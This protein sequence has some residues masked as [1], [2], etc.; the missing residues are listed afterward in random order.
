MRQRGHGHNEGG[1]WRISVAVVKE[2]VDAVL[3]V[4]WK[5]AERQKSWKELALGISIFTGEM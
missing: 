1:G 5:L 3:V 2:V 4:V